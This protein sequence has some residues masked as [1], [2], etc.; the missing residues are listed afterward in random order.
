MITMFMSYF[1]DM[2]IFFWNWQCEISGDKSGYFITTER[3]EAIERSLEL[4][5]DTAYTC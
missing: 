5:Q 4:M 2:T 3:F 1:L